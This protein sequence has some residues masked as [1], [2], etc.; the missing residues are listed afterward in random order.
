MPRLTVEI[1]GQE[2]TSEDSRALIQL[3]YDDYWAAQLIDHHTQ[4]GYILPDEKTA[5]F[6]LY[7]LSN[8]E[9]TGTTNF[10]VKGTVYATCEGNYKTYTFVN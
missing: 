3:Q 2:M 5:T 4:E 6:F 7:V 9:K 1:D 10:K 8:V